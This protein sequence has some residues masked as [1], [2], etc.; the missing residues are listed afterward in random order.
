MNK[1]PPS[2]NTRKHCSK[3]KSTGVQL[4]F[5]YFSIACSERQREERMA[6]GD[7]HQK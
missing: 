3:K 6:V 4:L 2:L 1:Q 5:L 7:H